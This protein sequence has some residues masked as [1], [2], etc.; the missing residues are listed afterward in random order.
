[1]LSTVAEAPAVRQLPVAARLTICQLLHS[2]TVGGAEVLAARI[3]RRLHERYRF[4]FACLDE[5]GPVGE[6]LQAEGFTVHQLARRPGL[7]WRCPLRLAAALR[8]ESVDVVHAHQYTPFFYALAGR[9][10][11]QR[12]PILFTEH[13]RHQPDHPRRK[14]I[15]AN[16]L[17]LLK[18]DR[19][20]GVGEAVRRALIDNEGFPADRVEVLY[21]GIDTDVFGRPGNQAAARI[22]MGVGPDDFVLVQ[23]ARL[24]YLKD[25]VTAIR[26]LA[27]V[28]GDLPTV[29][30]VLVGDGPERSLVER[31]ANELGVTKLVR[32]LGTRHDVH[33]LLAGA[34][35]FVLTSVSEGIPL[36]VLEAMAA[37]L[38]VVATEVGGLAEIV[39]HGTTG[40]LAEARNPERLAAHVLRL[41]GDRDLRRRMGAAGHDRVR[42]HFDESRMCDDYGRLYEELA[43]V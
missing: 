11:G 22:A 43:R 10:R 17:L 26:M 34:D 5:I 27:K 18:R 3:A 13:G 30:L 19:I 12:R 8:R 23:V 2:L 24:D 39:K 16:R 40:F 35:L 20:I 25:H 7:D 42:L 37:G 1:M 41:A 15:I 32:M 6:Q 33:T 9:L 29:R 28:A 36:T 31:T 38:P 21:N 14:R 4:V